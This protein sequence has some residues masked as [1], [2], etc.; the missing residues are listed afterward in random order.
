MQ[1]CHFL[2]SSECPPSP[3]FLLCAAAYVRILGN[4]GF[5]QRQQ[6]KKVCLF[7]CCCFYQVYYI[8][9]NVY[10]EVGI[11][12]LFFIVVMRNATSSVFSCCS[13]QKKASLGDEIEERRE[14]KRKIISPLHKLFEFHIYLQMWRPDK[15]S[16]SKVFKIAFASNE[17]KIVLSPNGAF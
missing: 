4:Y 11:S 8:Y 6:G 5:P 9:I 13:R 2:S 17:R 3:S 7:W 10:L 14:E 16:T 15:N 12:Q 1:N